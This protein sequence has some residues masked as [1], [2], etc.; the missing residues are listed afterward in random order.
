MEVFKTP[1]HD[2]SINVGEQAARDR[3]KGT[4]LATLKKRVPSVHYIANYGVDKST[5]LTNQ[6]QLHIAWDINIPVS[7]DT[8]PTLLTTFQCC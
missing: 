3:G 4:R 1:I 6:E 2:K 5:S 8:T 7:W